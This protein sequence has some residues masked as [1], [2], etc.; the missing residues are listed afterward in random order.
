VAVY[1]VLPVRAALGLKV[2]VLP[3]AAYVTTPDTGALVDVTCRVNCGGV[4]IVEAVIA[5]LKVAVIIWLRGTSMAAGGP[6]RGIVEITVGGMT[7]GAAPVV[8]VH[9]KLLTIS[10][11]FRFVTQ[12]VM[13]AVYIVLTKRLALGIKVAMLF[14]V[15]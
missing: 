8:N 1:S 5:S 9:T 7:S 14:V 3:T 6:V 4:V 11:P 15:S 2:A 13:V 10:V 12:D